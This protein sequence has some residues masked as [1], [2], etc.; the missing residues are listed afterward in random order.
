MSAEAAL[1][2]IPTYSSYPGEPYLIERYLVKKGLL[3]RETDYGR[4][5]KGVLEILED[6]VEARRTQSSKAQELVSGFE[7]PVEVI[8][9]EIERVKD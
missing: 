3:V 1:L 9:R 4:I 7:D 8:V 5:T 6:P 2:G